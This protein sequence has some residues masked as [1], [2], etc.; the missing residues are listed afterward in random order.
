MEYCAPEAP[1]SWAQVDSFETNNC[2][3]I[4]PHCREMCAAT[5]ETLVLLL[6]P[7][8][9]SSVIRVS[10]FIIRLYIRTVSGRRIPYVGTIDIRI[11]AY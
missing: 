7:A 2:F 11:V 5:P 10:Y 3:L 4:V 9:S 1:W 8:T 6:G